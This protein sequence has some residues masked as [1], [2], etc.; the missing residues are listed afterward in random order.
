MVRVRL[1][2]IGFTQRSAKDFFTTL[3]QHGV[4]KIIDV[5]LSNTSQ[6]A[7]F[8][9]R[10]DLCYFLENLCDCKYVHRITWAPTQDL[11]DAYRKKSIGWDKYKTIFLDSLIQRRIEKET[12]VVDLN[13]SCLLCSEYDANA[14]HRRLVAE[15][16]ITKFSDLKIAHL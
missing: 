4:Q 14:C 11:L 8:A 5:R 1:F 6:M 7:G 12:S 9:K 16:L 3:K 2:T 10:S 15:Y 13:C